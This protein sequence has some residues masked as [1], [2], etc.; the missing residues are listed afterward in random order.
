MTLKKDCKL[1]K[2]G[3]AVQWGNFKSGARSVKTR[4]STSVYGA[5]DDA[6]K[7]FFFNK[8]FKK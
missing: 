1:E 8:I 2:T 5:F 7:D 3:N 6:I 4:W